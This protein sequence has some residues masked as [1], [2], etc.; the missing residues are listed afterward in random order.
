MGFDFLKHLSPEQRARIEA[1]QKAHAKDVAEVRAMD[2]EKLC[3]RATYYL[4]QSAFPH[5]F[6]PGEPV[7]DGAIAHV[8]I[9]ELIRRVREK[10]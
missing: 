9:P 3:E 6:Q 5:Q 10:P 2:D 1:R 4:S 7:Y 8:I